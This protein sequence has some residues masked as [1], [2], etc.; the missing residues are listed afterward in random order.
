MKLTI[1]QWLDEKKYFIPNEYPWSTKKKRRGDIF[2]IHKETEAEIK[3]MYAAYLD[4]MD[5]SVNL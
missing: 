1:E 2:L 3:M 4:K 5:T